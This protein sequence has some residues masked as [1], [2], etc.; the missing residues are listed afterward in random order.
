MKS[1]QHT[2]YSSTK[3]YA[4]KYVSRPEK[5]RSHMFKICSLR[6]VNAFI[7]L[8]NFFTF[9]AL[10]DMNSKKEPHIQPDTQ[11]TVKDQASKKSQRDPDPWLR[12]N[13]KPDFSSQDE[14]GERDRERIRHGIPSRILFSFLLLSPAA[15]NDFSF[16]NLM[17]VLLAGRQAG[18]LRFASFVR[19]SFIFFAPFGRVCLSAC[20]SVSRS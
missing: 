12:R 2:P 9:F 7:K 16:P 8:Y 5:E 19:L 4:S 10:K 15:G 17:S 11:A 3:E 1:Q 20:L 18:K 6:L 13:W 14:G